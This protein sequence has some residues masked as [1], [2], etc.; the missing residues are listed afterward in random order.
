MKHFMENDTFGLYTA[1]VYY[2]W[3]QAKDEG[4]DVAHLKE[5]CQAIQKRFYADD[6]AVT[7]GDYELACALEKQMREAP[8]LKNYPY[9]EP[10]DYARILEARPKHTKEVAT[11]SDEEMKR[12]ILG[13]WTGRI[14]GCLLGKPLEFWKYKDLKGMLT[15]TN[16]YPVN[17]YVSTEDFTPEMIEKYH[18]VTGTPL[19]NQPWIDELEGYAPIDDDT[20][21]TVLNMKVM[22]VFGYEFD[23]GDVLYA[24]LNWLPAGVCC[25]AERVAYKNAVEGF[26]AP[27][28][29]R[30]GNPYREWVGAQI[31]AEIFGWVNPGNPEA[32][33]EAAFRDACISHTRNGI[34]G[35][36]FTAAMVAA[37]MHTTDI[38]EVIQA[39]LRE[40]PENSRIAEA[41]RSVIADYES[42]MPLKEAMDK[43][44]LLHNEDNIFEWC[45]IIPNEKIVVLSLL[46]SEGDFTRAIGN[47]VECAFDTD[48]NAAVVGAVMG[49]LY[50]V[51]KIES[52]WIAP[53]G[54]RLASTV[55]DESMNEIAD[56]TERTF[57]IAK[58]EITPDT[59]LKRRYDYN[60]S[61]DIE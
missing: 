26:S 59:R 45:H 35:E 46:Y 34:Y 51:E 53:L 31:R 16:N 24:W 20:N 49:T 7:L 6:R 41:V 36:M 15:E 32:A 55:L 4:R 9:D 8:I 54:G 52:K 3:Q 14:A 10:S 11:M 40:I 27:D 44:H 60:E 17:R 29:A 33:A 28:T 42:G 56:L 12:R 19:N 37:A 13:G 22:E 39:G 1:R 43:I 38:K 2:D 23:P 21:Y 57:K 61:F 48:S 47:C 25:T 18:I 30:L 5:T 58:R 50:G